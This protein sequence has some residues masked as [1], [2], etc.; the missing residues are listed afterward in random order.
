MAVVNRLG[1]NLECLLRILACD[2]LESGLEVLA[3]C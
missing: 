3:L 2:E 1:M